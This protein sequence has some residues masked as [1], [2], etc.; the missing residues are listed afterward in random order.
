MG[1]FEP[2]MLGAYGPWAANLAGEVIMDTAGT[3][4][5]GTC[6]HSHTDE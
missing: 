5:A 4:S 6:C 3:R 2:N 1:T